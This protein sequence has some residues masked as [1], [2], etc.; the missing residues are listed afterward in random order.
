MLVTLLPR[1]R[2]ISRSGATV[3]VLERLRRFNV[4]G[5]LRFELE[6]IR[7]RAN[8]L[9]AERDAHLHQRDC[10]I[11]EGNEYLRQRDIA[12][13]ER[14]ELLRQRDVAIGERNEYLRQRDIAIG[15]RAEVLRQLDVA[16]GERNEYLRQRDVALGERNEYLRQ[17][18]VAI[19]ENNEYLRQRDV[20]IGQKNLLIDWAER[21]AHRTDLIARPAAATCDRIVLFLHLAK[22]GGVTLS[23]IFVRNLAT[24]EFLRILMAETQ[25]SALGTWSHVAIERALGRLPESD[26][27]KLRVVW[28]H[29]RQGVQAHLPMPCAVVTLLREPVDRVI[30]AYYY[31]NGDRASKDLK[32]LEDYLARP[33]CNVGLDNYMT[34]ILSGRAA[35]DPVTAEPD[36]TTDNFPCP[37]EADFEAA[38][39]HLDGYMVVGTT[40]RF[41]E[42]LVVLGSDLC[43]SLSDLVHRPLNASASRSRDDVIP[44]S[45]REKILSWNRYDAM[46][47][48]RARAHLD[49]RIASYPGDFGRDFALFRK[50]NSLFQEGAPA[51]ELRR[52]ERE[53]RM[54]GSGQR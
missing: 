22:T 4:R 30:S 13:G 41:D 11:G 36:P 37:T 35:L 6:K 46:L 27:A 9:A 52:L 3:R 51:Q 28:G 32:S 8:V 2:G 12:I 15:E 25:A 18:D 54:N 16:L 50:L 53:A 21:H 7:S 38:A 40:D 44:D 14:D 20:A 24:E 19:G 39:S 5:K 26:V 47:F 33:H 29:Y 45:L 23:D 10:S 1:P 17:R 43:W 31:T 49:R 42:T 48:E 34:R